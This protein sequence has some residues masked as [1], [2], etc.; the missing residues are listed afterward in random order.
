VQEV[1]RGISGVALP[2]AQDRLRKTCVFVI[3]HYAVQDHMLAEALALHN[4]SSVRA[5]RVQVADL[6]IASNVHRMMAAIGVE[7][8]ADLGRVLGVATN[9]YAYTASDVQKAV[10]QVQEQQPQSAR[11]GPAGSE[12][13]HA[14]NSGEAPQS[15]RNLQLQAAAAVCRSFLLSAQLRR[16]YRL[17]DLQWA[18]EDTRRKILFDPNAGMESPGGD[19]YA[20]ELSEIE[21]L[22]LR[23]TDAMTSSDK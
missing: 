15:Q 3:S 1:P 8:G 17:P 22:A 13:S 12:S 6:N 11:E 16:P 18:S 9:A 2:D 19:E 20:V 10:R 7:T 4:S 14:R 23:A 5:L 21:R